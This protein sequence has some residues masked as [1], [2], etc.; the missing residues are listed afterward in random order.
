MLLLYIILWFSDHFAK[1]YPPMREN[2]QGEDIHL[3]Y[4]Q[5]V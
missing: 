5:M 3:D 1:V 4:I 2:E